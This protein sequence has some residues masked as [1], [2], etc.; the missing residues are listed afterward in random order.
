MFAE[1]P[2]SIAMTPQPRHTK[3]P[4]TSG[5]RLLQ[6]RLAKAEIAPCLPHQYL[7]GTWHL[8]GFGERHRSAEALVL[9]AEVLRRF[10]LT[11][12]TGVERHS[13]FDPLLLQL[14][15]A[16]EV[17]YAPRIVD[18]LRVA[19]VYNADRVAQRAVR[20]LRTQAIASPVAIGTFHF[21]ETSAL[22][23]VLSPPKGKPEA[24]FAEALVNDLRHFHSEE[25]PPPD[26]AI[27]TGFTGIR[28][29]TSPELDHLRDALIDLPHA[30]TR[31][32]DNP[33]LDQIFFYP[34]RH[35]R[36]EVGGLLDLYE[37]SPRALFPDGETSDQEAIDQLSWRSPAWT[38]F[39]G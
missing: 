9:I 16:W 32:N 33:A 14:G 17:Q 13:A 36:G 1:T 37:N 3:E 38:S 2:Y 28:G 15:L 19:A 21:G 39:S 35:G 22:L 23:G 29:P 27:V 4:Q 18:G 12:V 7:I 11:I 5:L 20:T 8:P 34:S 25:R 10:D 6:R 24:E 30:L 26:L 31:Q